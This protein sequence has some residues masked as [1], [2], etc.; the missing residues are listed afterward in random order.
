LAD[1]TVSS[2]CGYYHA[3]RYVTLDVDKSPNNLLHI[4]RAPESE[5]FSQEFRLT[6]NGD[7]A[8]DWIA[9]LYYLREDLAVDTTFA[10]GGPPEPFFPQLYNSDT[11]TYAAYAEIIYSLTERL[12]FTG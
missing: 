11:E 7:Q 4:I 5:Q 1:V 8:L 3:E 9:G 2:I 12:S 6:S 10:F